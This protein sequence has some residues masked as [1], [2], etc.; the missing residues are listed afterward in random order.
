MAAKLTRKDV[1]EYRSLAKKEGRDVSRLTDDQIIQQIRILKG[2]LHAPAKSEVDE[3]LARAQETEKVF[4]RCRMGVLSDLESALADFE[5]MD[6]RAS[7][8]PKGRKPSPLPKRA[9]RMVALQ[10]ALLAHPP[11][12]LSPEYREA[13][14]LVDSWAVH[15]ARVME[16]V[17]AEGEQIL[18]S[19]SG[20]LASMIERLKKASP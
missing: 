10:R 7:L 1:L 4:H 15:A 14:N 9:V 8:K 17:N 3:I 16:K 12:M 20:R 11:S 13:L 5:E 18:R 19:I 2:G 6:R